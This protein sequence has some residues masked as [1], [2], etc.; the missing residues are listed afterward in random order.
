V[1]GEKA[2]PESRIVRGRF[3]RN[4]YG[5]RRSQQNSLPGH[6]SGLGSGQK[7]ASSSGPTPENS[8]QIKEFI[9]PGNPREFFDIVYAFPPS[10]Q[11][12]P[13]AKYF[14]SFSGGGGTSDG[15]IDV[16]PPFVGDICDLFYEFRLPETKPGTAAAIMKTFDDAAPRKAPK[17]APAKTRRRG[18]GR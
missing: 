2:Q 10:G 7:W 13:G 15:P 16:F 1:Y 12:D 8:V 5:D 9:M 18:K 14:V 17:K 3:R 4:D 11:A 6:F